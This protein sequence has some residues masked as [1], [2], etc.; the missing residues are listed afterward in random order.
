MRAFNVRYGLASNPIPEPAT[1]DLMIGGFVLTG[2]ALRRR[3]T[4]AASGL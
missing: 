4:L 3:R 1:W 2:A